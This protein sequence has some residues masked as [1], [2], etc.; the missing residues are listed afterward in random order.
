MN[1]RTALVA[2]CGIDCGVCELYLARYNTE[3]MDHLIASGFSEDVLPCDGCRVNRGKC[4]ILPFNCATYECADEKG[5]AYCSEC[6]EFPC[7]KLM[8]CIDKAEKLQHN[9]KTYN[10]ALI[11]KNGVKAFI[12]QSIKIKKA[13]FK[14]KMLIGNGPQ[15]SENI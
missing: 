5:V 3:L 11:K 15:I 14:G 10:L 1:H 8:P 13:Y 2:P 9:M 12:Q 4:P 6:S 7:H